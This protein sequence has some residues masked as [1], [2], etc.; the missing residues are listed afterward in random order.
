MT[1]HHVKQ[2]VDW[3]THHLQ[4]RL[5]DLTD[6]GI[7]H[8]LV[9]RKARLIAYLSHGVDLRE[10][11]SALEA[12]SFEL[13]DNVNVGHISDTHPAFLELWR[14]FQLDEHARGG[15]QLV[16]HDFGSGQTFVSPDPDPRQAFQFYQDVAE[17]K[18]SPKVK[19]QPLHA[20]GTASHM[21]ERLVALNF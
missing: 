11:L 9:N 20:A 5:L 14:V 19:S 13:P 3:V 2:G 18:Y 6:K 1:R 15:D 8:A 10:R 21:V 4:D 12:A 7:R 16:Y 17:R